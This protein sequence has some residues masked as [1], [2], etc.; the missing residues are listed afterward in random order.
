MKAI[1]RVQSICARIDNF[2]M[3]ALGRHI[4]HKFESSNEE[5][6]L[7]GRCGLPEPDSAGV[8]KMDKRVELE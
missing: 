6:T 3:L 1:E 7:R 2:T 8:L 4:V 5:G